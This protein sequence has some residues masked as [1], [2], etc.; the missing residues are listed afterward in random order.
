MSVVIY[1]LVSLL[2]RRL[3]ELAVLRARTDASKVV[4]VR[5][6]ILTGGRRV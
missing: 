3:F 6:W 5:Y 1:S 2:A 4:E